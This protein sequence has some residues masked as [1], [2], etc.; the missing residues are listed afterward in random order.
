MAKSNG[1][2]VNSEMTRMMLSMA[3][4]L[5]SPR[6]SQIWCASV[7]RKVKRDSESIAIMLPAAA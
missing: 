5:V 7:K 2:R 6:A 1:N 4:Y 3:R